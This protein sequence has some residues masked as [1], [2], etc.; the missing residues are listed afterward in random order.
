[1]VE[2]MEREQRLSIFERVARGDLSPEQGAELL[3]VSRM[4]PG[5]TEN[6]R[7]SR[8]TID[9]DDKETNG[10]DLGTTKWKSVG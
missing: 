2:N 6:F 10:V 4:G 1:M 3:K 5:R 8:E 9:L 7:R